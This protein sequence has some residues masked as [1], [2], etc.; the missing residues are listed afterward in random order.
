MLV[1]AV[2]AVSAAFTSCDNGD[3]DENGN[4]NDVVKLLET[5]T[6]RD[7][8]YSKFEYDEKD[9]IKK[10]YEYSNGE[11]WTTLTFA[12]NGDDLVKVSL[13]FSENPSSIYENNYVRNGNTII[14]AD[15]DDDYST[16]ITV[17]NEGY[18]TKIVYI[19]G[20]DE[21]TN[22]FQY[23]DGNL[24]KWT[25]TRTE[26]GETSE[27]TVEPKYD[28]KNSPFLHCKTPRWYL[29]NCMYY[30]QRFM[31]IIWRNNFTGYEYEYDRNGYPTKQTSTW[32]GVTTFKY[33]E[34]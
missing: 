25:R 13:V 8:S 17:N 12:Y 5:I 15:N 10:I 27:T 33:I 28:S 34:K 16:T 22:T 9:R 26:D 6:E 18:A 30:D 4:D 32:S 1:I 21:E 7:G 23:Q 24:T 29:W 20:D 31:T 11:I 19:R 14:H 3:E 2:L